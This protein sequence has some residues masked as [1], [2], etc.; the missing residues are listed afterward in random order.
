MIRVAT[1]GWMF[2]F[3]TRK[4]LKQPIAAP[5]MSAARKPRINGLAYAVAARS[6]PVKRLQQ[7]AALTAMI[8]PTEISVPAEDDTTSVMPTARITSSDARLMIS[9]KYP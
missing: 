5:T 8:A 2:N 6:P 4:P 3:A 7:T 9:I 1:I